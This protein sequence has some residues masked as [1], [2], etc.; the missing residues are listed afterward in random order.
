MHHHPGDQHEHRDSPVDDDWTLWDATVAALAVVGIDIV[1]PGD[2][3][4]GAVLQLGPRGLAVAVAWQPTEEHP[5]PGDVLA[6][7]VCRTSGAEPSVRKMLDLI[8][9]GFLDGAGLRTT[10]ADG[11]LFVVH[12]DLKLPAPAAASATPRAA[13]PAPAVTAAPPRPRRAGWLPR[14]RSRRG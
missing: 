7:N 2:G 14:I 6:V 13:R 8:L 4:P 9:Q 1:Q 5:L 3:R 10:F 12:P 11:H